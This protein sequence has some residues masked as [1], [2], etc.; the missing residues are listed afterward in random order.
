MTTFGTN[1]QQKDIDEVIRET[2]DFARVQPAIFLGGAALLGFVAARFLKS[3][4]Q[5]A[6]AAA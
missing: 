4:G 1:I 3:S 5:Q 6:A 2:E